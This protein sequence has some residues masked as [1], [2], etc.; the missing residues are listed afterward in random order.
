MSKKPFELPK[1]SSEITKLFA[2]IATE[3]P[4]N[5]PP[6]RNGLM[7][8]TP[9]MARD[10]LRRNPDNRALRPQLVFFL[11][12]EIVTGKWK[13]NGQTISFKKNGDLNDG[14]HRLISCVIADQPIMSHVVVDVDNNAFPT[15]DTGA[16]RQVKD[17]LSAMGYA[18]SPALSAAVRWA[19]MYEGG[20]IATAHLPG[21]VSRLSPDLAIEFIKKHPEIADV[22]K[23]IQNKHY[24]QFSRLATPSIATFVAWKVQQIDELRGQVFIEQ[25]SSGENLPKTSPIYML[26]S[27]LI[28]NQ[29]GVGKGVARAPLVNRLAW[30]VKAWNFWYTG[31]ETSKITWGSGLEDSFPR[32]VEDP[33]TV[34]TPWYLK[35]RKA[36]KAMA[37]EIEAIAAE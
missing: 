36:D 21:K 13:V 1:H 31:T 27:K 2:G 19:I 14:Q 17:V 33:K 15:V 32:F 37:A 23:E 3:K 16:T 30:H 25:L 8:I 4:K 11:V 24:L 28:M 10:W 5:P 12:N 7:T 29:G 22:A 34:L 26:R 35:T 6:K 18:A 9:T 20:T